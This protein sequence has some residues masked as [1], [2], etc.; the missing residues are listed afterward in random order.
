MSILIQRNFGALCL[1]GILAAA[2]PGVASADDAS[3]D[4]VKLLQ[5]K[6]DQSI[7]M[8]EALAARVQELEAKQAATSAAPAAAPVVAAGSQAPPTPT[9]AA[10]LQTVEQQ[11]NQIET[12]NAA[13]QGDDSGLTVH[14][15]AD[16]NIGNH[17]PFH[18]YEK[19]AS[20]NNLDLYLTPKLGD[21]WLS[22]FELNFEVDHNGNF[23]VDV[24]RG[25]L[26]YQF[27]DAATAWV[28]RFH[29]PY[30][31]VNTAFHHGVWLNDALRRPSFLMFEDQGGV[32]P[33]HTV[34]AWLTGAARGES[35]KVL[36]DVFAGNGQQI[37][38]G[39]IDMRSGGNEHGKLIYGGRL[40]Y[41]WTAGS[42]E[43]LTLGVNALDSKI[44][45]DQIPQNLTDVR[46]AGAFAV[47]DT[48]LWEIVSEAYWFDNV[49]LYRGLGT[50]RSEAYFVQVGY[51][52]PSFVP[53]VRYERAHLDQTDQYFA[54]Q[55]TG[56][57]YY[58]TAAGFRRDLNQKVAVKFEVAN[59]HYTDRTV[60]EINEFLSQ[61]AIRF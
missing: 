47:Y 4:T 57:S 56:A 19:G 58:R 20:L 31:Y 38:G 34:G 61:L 28:G 40:G 30:G 17:N 29:T 48:D 59:T 3:S 27:S 53:Y 11:I 14:G 33:A 42:L 46:I 49:S 44:N 1:A 23:G 51:R 25:Q 5:Q 6:L 36:Y 9:E 12:A 37:I 60:G 2:M 21:K 54:Q 24:E 32:L 13:R 35:G 41:Q 22:L 15:F 39:L 43:G 50:H 8:I 10:R 16:V 45:D 7:K 18:A 26:G 52:L 55:M